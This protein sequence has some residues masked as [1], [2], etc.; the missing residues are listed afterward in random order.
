MELSA[1]AAVPVA[2][3]SPRA[4]RA[5]WVF[6]GL[7][8]FAIVATGATRVAPNLTLA[9][10]VGG[11]TLVAARR[12]LLAWTTMLGLIVLVILFIPIRRYTLQAGIPIPLE[13][14]RVI[15]AGVAL[16]WA[17]ALLIDPQV[18]LKP[19]GL[20]GPVLTIWVAVLCSL[21]LNPGKVAPITGD[22]IKAVTFFSSFFFVMYFVSSVVDRRSVVDA[23]VKILVGGAT[24][25]AVLAVIEWRTG[26]TPFDHLQQYIP[27]L[28]FQ[29][30]NVP[31][32]PGRGGHA[33][34]Y[35]SAQHAIALGAALVLLM[36][37]ALYLFRR[38][39]SKLWI[40]CAG[41]IVIGSLATGSRTAV[42]MLVVELCVFLRHK[43]THTKRLLPLLLP[44]MVAIQFVMPGALHSFKASFFP[45]GGIVAQ[46]NGVGAGRPDSGRLTHLGPAMKQWLQRPFFGQGFSTRLTS[47][48]DVKMT[49]NILDN[50][51]LGSLLELG[52][53]GVFGLAW[54]W[55]RIGRRLRSAAKGVDD[56]WSWLL[57]SLAAGMTAFV[58]GMVTYD[59]FSFTQVTFLQFI[60][61]GLS[62]AA[63]RL[64]P[65]R[66]PRELDPAID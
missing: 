43:P 54:L 33:R 47:T 32:T 22:V 52:A 63:L 23:F 42:I 35:G 1:Q 24:V 38:T 6:V 58:I 18:R 56:D 27:V 60:L 61:I 40:G 9:A 5:F 57:I 25:L 41:L 64:T 30:Q 46:E 31:A 8:L 26:Y 4:V 12:F 11:L 10:V 20:T 66:G 59:A 53:V 21:A 51:W 37:L 50:Q 36:P 49:D 17:G 29:P 55:I 45:Q 16:A 2:G 44:L 7:G 28:D 39:R 48:H 3:P 14:Y 15:I 13:P 19:T 62:V 65:E 34:A